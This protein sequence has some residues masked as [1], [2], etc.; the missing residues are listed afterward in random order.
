MYILLSHLLFSSVPYFHGFI[1]FFDVTFY[2]FIVLMYSLFT[3]IGE[4]YEK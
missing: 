1:A 2:L 3:L 4:I